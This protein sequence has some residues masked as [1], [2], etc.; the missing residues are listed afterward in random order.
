MNNWSDKGS[1]KNP[2]LLQPMSPLPNRHFS[3]PSLIA[4][5]KTVISPFFNSPI[6]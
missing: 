4:L 5:G 6:F 2:S 3:C 1:I